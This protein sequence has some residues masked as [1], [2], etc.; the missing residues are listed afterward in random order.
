MG[1]PEGGE[2]GDVERAAPQAIAIAEAQ[3]AGLDDV[4]ERVGALVAVG[5]RVLGAAAADRI[6]DEENGARHDAPHW[7]TTPDSVASFA[8][9]AANRARV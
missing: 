6:E 7:L 3:R 9:A 5:R 1:E 2:A 8:K 4:A